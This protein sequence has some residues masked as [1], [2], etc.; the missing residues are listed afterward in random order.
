NGTVATFTDTDQT[1]TAKS[2]TASIDWGDGTR[3]TGVVT[4]AHNFNVAGSHT[5]TAVGPYKVTTSI[6][7]TDGSVATATSNVSVH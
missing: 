4:G 6:T 5:Y 7:G 1:A 2:F 3:S